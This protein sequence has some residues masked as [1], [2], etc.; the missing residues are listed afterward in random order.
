MLA[1][2][3]YWS[4]LSLAFL[5]AAWRVLSQPFL[6]NKTPHRADAPPKTAVVVAFRNEALDVEAAVRLSAP[7]VAPFESRS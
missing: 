4:L 7:H 1:A 5:H 3:A 6:W 2:P